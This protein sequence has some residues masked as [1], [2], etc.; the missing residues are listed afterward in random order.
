VLIADILLQLGEE[1]GYGKRD[2]EIENCE[3]RINLNAFNLRERLF[4]SCASGSALKAYSVLPI[5]A[6][7]LFKR[8]LNKWFALKKRTKCQNDFS[9]VLLKRNKALPPSMLIL[10]LHKK[11]K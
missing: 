1:E 3:K 8:D 6:S 11:R 5:A 4:S 9:Q 7:P 2:E 10:L